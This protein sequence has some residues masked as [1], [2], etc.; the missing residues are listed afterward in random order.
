M[1]DSIP[2]L[3]HDA[4]LQKGE[5]HPSI[6]SA[7]RWFVGNIVEPNRL[8]FY[9]STLSKISGMNR[10]TDVCHKTLKDI[11]DDKPVSDKEF[12]GL[13]WMLRDMNDKKRRPNNTKKE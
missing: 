5:I 7:K 4:S 12:L 1:S 8:K 10:A 11:A 2:T 9:L 6:D 3:T 13:C